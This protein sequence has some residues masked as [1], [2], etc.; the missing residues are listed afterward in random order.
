MAMP[1]H[2]HHPPV[3]RE[4][5]TCLISTPLFD[6]LARQLPPPTADEIALSE[7]R[8]RRAHEHGWCTCGETTAEREDGRG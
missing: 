4:E 8:H 5:R 1:R 6:H 3:P 7:R 2:Q